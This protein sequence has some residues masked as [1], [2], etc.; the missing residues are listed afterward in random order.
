M[1][2][3]TRVGETFVWVCRVCGKPLGLCTCDNLKRYKKWYPGRE[4]D[5]E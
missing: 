3:I 4:A 1:S 5:H 2:P